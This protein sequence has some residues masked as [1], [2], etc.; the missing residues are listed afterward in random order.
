MRFKTPLERH[1]AVGTAAARLGER[2]FDVDEFVRC[3]FR[4]MYV[5]EFV[6]FS[7]R[8]AF[9]LCAGVSVP[10]RVAAFG[11]HIKDRVGA[12]Q[13]DASFSSYYLANI[14]GHPEVDAFGRRVAGWLQ[15]AELRRILNW[16]LPRPSEWSS[17][18]ESDVASP[19]CDSRWLA[20]RFL[21]TYVNDWHTASL[22]DEYRWAKGSKASVIS[23]QDLFL[24]SVP[25]DR[26][27]AEIARRAVEGEMR[28]PRSLLS[29]GVELLL[30]GEHE[31]A[32]ALFQ[33]ALTVSPGSWVR[34]C[35][36]FCLVPSDP[37][38]AAA[39]FRE[40]LA[41]GFEPHLLHANLAATSRLQGD[42]AAVHEHARAGL[43]STSENDLST[44]YLWGF[45]GK[46]LILIKNASIP[47]YLKSA[48][49]WD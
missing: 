5:G 46:S 13:P 26:L 44:A 48:L 20:D 47:G 18:P 1:V 33:G 2:G 12:P 19:V 42:I 8:V 16:T 9:D 38:A 30:Q 7:S 15:Q 41:E 25:L 14:V 43:D 37:Q 49:S 17:L 11:N 28:D 35:L 23:P 39:M 29:M 21:L 24:R 10:D 27:N 32:V 40:L 45:E 3:V 22:H 31:Q 6:R 36:A 34:N 4:P